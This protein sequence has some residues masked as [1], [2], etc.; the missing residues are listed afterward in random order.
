MTQAFSNN[1]DIIDV[2]DIIAR[3]EELE[4][5]IENIDDMPEGD[6]MKNTVEA[7][8]LRKECETLTELLNNLKGTGGDE[9]WRG[10]W[11][12][13]TM[14]KDS[15]FEDSMDEFVSECYDIDA[16]KLPS[17]I[18]IKFDYVAL[19]SDYTSVD[20]DGTTYWVR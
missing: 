15:Y 20:Y 5:E 4:A 13:V 1:D 12:P 9:E 10:D 7:D 11:Y 17:F 6:M 18:S 3:V 19:Q 14:I 16:L 8:E 2:R